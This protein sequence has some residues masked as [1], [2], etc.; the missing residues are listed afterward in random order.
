MRVTPDDCRRAAPAG[1]IVVCGRRP[2]EY[3]VT[4]LK[5]PR[6]IAVGEGGVIGFDLGGGR[7]E[8]ELEQV[9]MPDGRISKRIM[10]T[11][12]MPF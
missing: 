8:P 3:R 2:D 7:V 11:V 10:V 1:D 4:E 6:G 12:K 9:M 5:P